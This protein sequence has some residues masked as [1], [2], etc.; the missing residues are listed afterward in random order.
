LFVG[1]W[2]FFH[3]YSA[4]TVEDGEGVVT[5]TSTPVEITERRSAITVIV[6]MI[7]RIKRKYK[8]Y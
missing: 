3:N 8:D 1:K 2:Y 7:L 5:N 6:T 4:E